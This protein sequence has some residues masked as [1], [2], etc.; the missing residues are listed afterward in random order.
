MMI[1]ALFMLTGLAAQ[2]LMFG[3]VLSVFIAMVMLPFV[4][5]SV[6]F[7]NAIAGAEE[8][9]RLIITCSVVLMLGALFMMIPGLW[10]KALLFGAILTVF[11]TLI[12]LPFI[13]FI[14][15]GGRKAL[16][17]VDDILP[18]H[19]LQLFN[20]LRLTKKTFGLLINFGESSLHFEKYYFDQDS[21]E[22]IFYKTYK[23]RLN[24]N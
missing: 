13:M 19:R 6:F 18:E 5:Y 24:N 11:V 17:A 23:D 12:L 8:I 7:K 21:N 15:L 3:A 22:I 20:Y 10:L 2:A 9:S 4:I 14:K 16:K 1:G